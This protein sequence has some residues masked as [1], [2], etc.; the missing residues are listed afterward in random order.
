MLHD[1]YL[2][3]LPN[4]E[5]AWKGKARKHL[6]GW[7]EHFDGHVGQGEYCCENFF[8]TSKESMF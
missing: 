2:D 8:L 4:F 6:P 5:Q 7:N 3:E 1:D